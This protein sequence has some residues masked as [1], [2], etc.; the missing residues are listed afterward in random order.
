MVNICCSSQF[1]LSFCKMYFYIIYIICILY[2]FYSC[3]VAY[4][5]VTDKLCRY[6]P[7]AAWR[8]VRT[9]VKSSCE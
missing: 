3:S 1:K 6:Y 8:D 7:C 4:P 2:T 9:N 5:P